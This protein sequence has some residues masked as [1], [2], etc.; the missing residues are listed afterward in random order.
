MLKYGLVFE[1]QGDGCDHTIAC[2][3]RFE[4]IE[5]SDDAHAERLACKRMH[6][7][8]GSW[9]RDGETVI[10][11][12]TLV[13]IVTELPVAQ[14]AAGFQAAEREMARASDN[15]SER[16]QYERLHRKFGGGA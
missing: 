1:Q 11:S 15:A 3:T 6:E 13:R 7:D 16:A 10:E 4:I 5:A 2:G 8:D 9:L 12:L 14:W